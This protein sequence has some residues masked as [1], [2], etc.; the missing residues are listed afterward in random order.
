MFRVLCT[1]DFLPS[2]GARAT[3]NACSSGLRT[4]F[5]GVAN[6]ADLSCGGHGPSKLGSAHLKPDRF[7]NRLLDDDDWEIL[8][9]AVEGNGPGDCEDAWLRSLALCDPR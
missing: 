6:T 7:R 4:R 9:D 3:A 5:L 1:C 2:V 8:L